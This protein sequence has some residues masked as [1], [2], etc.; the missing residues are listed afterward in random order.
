MRDSGCRSQVSGGFL[1]TSRHVQLRPGSGRLAQARDCTGVVRH[2]V[3]WASGPAV[4]LFNGAKIIVVLESLA[5]RASKLHNPRR[6][7]HSLGC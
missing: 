7:W 5:Q 3:P 6:S 4:L 2:V 1:A